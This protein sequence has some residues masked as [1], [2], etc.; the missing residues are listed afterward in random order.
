MAASR[1]WP[2]AFTEHPVRP[3]DRQDPLALL[4][5]FRCT[6]DRMKGM[7]TGSP[8]PRIGFA[9]QWED[10]PERTWSY[11]A[12]NR[13]QRCSSQPIQPISACG[14]RACRGRP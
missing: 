11:A 12:W 10:I 13:G 6:C 2:G 3:A 14:Y 4:N 1:L 7:T 8:Q 5:E 9:C